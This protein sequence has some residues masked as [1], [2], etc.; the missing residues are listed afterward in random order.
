MYILRQI[1]KEQEAFWSHTRCQI[2]IV[3][4]FMSF[5]VIWIQGS[6]L[7]GAHNGISGGHDLLMPVCPTQRNSIQS[8]RKK[9]E[10]MLSASL[11]HWLC[12]CLWTYIC[13]W[14][15]V[16]TS[17]CVAVPTSMSVT[18]PTSVCVTVPI[19]MS[20]TISTSVCVAIPT[21]VCVTVPTSVWLY[22]HLCVLET[23]P[24][25]VCV[26]VPTYV[27]VWLHVQMCV[28][29]PAWLSSC[30]GVCPTFLL[31]CLYLSIRNP[32]CL[33]LCVVHIAFCLLLM[34]LFM[35]PSFWFSL[36][37]YQAVCFLVC[38]FI[39]LC[40]SFLSLTEFSHV[41]AMHILIKAPSLMG[42]THG[43]ETFPCQLVPPEPGIPVLWA[44]TY[45][46]LTPHL[47]P[48]ATHSLSPSR[49]DS[50]C[51]HLWLWGFFTLAHAL[52]A[53]LWHY[54]VIRHILSHVYV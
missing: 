38:H 46:V 17:V 10:T 33:S 3:L 9:A 31:V 49:T 32:A 22:L 50:A 15:T 35:C 52:G 40:L 16:P 39:C 27:C 20:V 2:Y 6:W 25:Y 53:A 41:C 14:V 12:F 30:L 11:F 24:T 29:M 18:I 54:C 48:E 1:I 13:V 47:L 42:R 7:T 43:L 19:Y 45:Q 44:Q 5:E 37:I 26:A 34:C 21:S 8:Q 51:P 28:C 4:P 23:V 36:S